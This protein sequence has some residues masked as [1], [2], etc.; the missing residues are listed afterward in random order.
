MTYLMNIFEKVSYDPEADVFY[1]SL[2]KWTIAETQPL[3]NWMIV[4][5][6][7]RGEVIWVEILSAKKHMDKVQEF[8]FSAKKVEEC[9]SS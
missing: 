4:D 7:S 9:I 5:K 6:D 2:R 1:F 3:S 8:L